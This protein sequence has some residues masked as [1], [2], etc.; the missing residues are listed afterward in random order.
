M[1]RARS[2]TLGKDDKTLTCHLCGFTSYHQS[3]V[4][5]R[6]CGHCDI[7]LDTLEMNVELSVELGLVKDGPLDW[8][9]LLRQGVDTLRTLRGVGASKPSG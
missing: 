8:L 1:T 6:Y 9:S 5:H 7:Y 3:D 2:Y 4:A